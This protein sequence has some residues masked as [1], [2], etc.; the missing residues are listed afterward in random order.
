MRSIADPEALGKILV[1]GASGFIGTWLA[2][3]LLGPGCDVVLAA[4][5]PPSEPKDA[6]WKI[7]KPRWVIL[8][9]RQPGAVEA[10]L[11]AERPDTV[12]HLAGTRGIGAPEG[13]CVACTEVN[14]AA[15]V[16]LLSAAKRVGVRRVVTVGSAEEYGRQPGPLQEDM[17]LLPETPYGVSKMAATRLAQLMATTEGCPV[18]V[19][20]PFTVY[21]PGQPRSMFVA[22]A[23]ECALAG[24]A[25]Q[26]TAGTQRRDLVYA[27]DV[28]SSMI[29]AATAPD[30]VG[31]VINA[32]TGKATPLREV[33]ELIWKIS[34]STAPLEIGARPAAATELFD[35]WADTGRE[36]RLLG[37]ENWITL[38]DGLKRTI[39]DAR[40]ALG[41]KGA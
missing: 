15:T 12:F 26:M 27:M 13:A 30:V 9:V 21:G 41:K 37:K 25:F 11:E 7:L 5:H 38:E 29:V 23:V 28:V 19:I 34:G 24:K 35:T 20:R 2:E 33:A 40:Y 32:G 36:E 18:T 8:D 31:Q 16:R 39:N 17:P 6:L 3:V 4:R 1:T 14:V 10:L 22:Q